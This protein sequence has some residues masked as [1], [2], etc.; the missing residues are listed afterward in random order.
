MIGGMIDNIIP[1]A[2]TANEKSSASSGD[3]NILDKISNII[4]GDAGE[5]IEDFAKSKLGGLFGNK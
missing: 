4:P 5:K 1:S 3:G 2:N